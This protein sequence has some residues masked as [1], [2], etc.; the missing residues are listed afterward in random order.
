MDSISQIDI[1]TMKYIYAFTGKGF[2]KPCFIEGHPFFIYGY[3]ASM[4]LVGWFLSLANWFFN[5]TNE[6]DN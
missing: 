2:K 6:K 4:E 3:I 1:S 5:H